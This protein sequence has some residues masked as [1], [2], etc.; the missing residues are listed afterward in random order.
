[1]INLEYVVK[2]ILNGD[3]RLINELSMVDHADILVKCLEMGQLSVDRY[4]VI[5]V[6]TLLQRKEIK[7]DD[8][9]R[10]AS[11]IRRGYF[12]SNKNYKITPLNIE[13]KEE[14]EDLI[15]YAVDKMDQ[16]GDLIDG[17]LSEN[18][19]DQLIISLKSHHEY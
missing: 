15:S 18:D 12:P 10:W 9:Q 7:E 19:L 8:A 4:S 5:L 14:D 2:N 3:A 16:L 17:K 1:M 6:L 11:F 13:Y